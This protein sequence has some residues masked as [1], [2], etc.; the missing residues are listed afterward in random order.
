MPAGTNE[1]VQ[2]AR[3]HPL[4]PAPAIEI[5]VRQLA[6]QTLERRPSVI[7]GRTGG[8]QIIVEFR[9]H[10]RLL[11]PIGAQDRVRRL[12][13]GGAASVVEVCQT[14]L[15]IQRTRWQCRADSESL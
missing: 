12:G 6:G 1:V 4:A 7:D 2:H 14:G 8:G 10:A 9:G 11:E 13:T 5:G 15:D 3:D